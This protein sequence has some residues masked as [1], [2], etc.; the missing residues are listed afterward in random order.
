MCLHADVF[1]LK[2]FGG[3][4]G[5]ILLTNVGCTGY[6]TTLFDCSARIPRRS[7]VHAEDAGVKCLSGE[8]YN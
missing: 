2:R 8:L 3:G 5:S 7:C 1:P 4:S 6:E